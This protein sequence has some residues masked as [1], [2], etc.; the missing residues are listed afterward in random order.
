MTEKETHD[1]FVFPLPDDVLVYDVDPRSR[2][3]HLGVQ[4]YDGRRTVLD[5]VQIGHPRLAQTRVP[6]VYQRRFLDFG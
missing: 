5:R 4:V 3:E 6:A 2:P 1:K